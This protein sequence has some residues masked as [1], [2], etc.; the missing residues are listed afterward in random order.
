M[1]QFDHGDYKNG[2]ESV[3]VGVSLLTSYEH[4]GMLNV[5]CKE[6]CTCN[7]TSFDTCNP[8][9]AWSE[10]RWAFVHIKVAPLTPGLPGSFAPTVGERL[11]CVTCLAPSS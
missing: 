4:M 8:N 9:M 1:T 2:E 3:V 7:G 5:A 11:C 10:A 6:G